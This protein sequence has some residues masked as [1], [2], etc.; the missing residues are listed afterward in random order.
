MTCGEAIISNQE[1]EAINSNQE[2]E[3][4]LTRSLTILHN[5]AIRLFKII[6]KWSN[7][8]MVV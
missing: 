4:N 6:S 1:Q 8:Q 3:A 7:G 5:L 2:Q